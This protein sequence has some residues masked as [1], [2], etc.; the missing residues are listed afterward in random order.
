MNKRNPVSVSSCYGSQG[1]V[2]K[3][4]V[5]AQFI[6]SSPA[7]KALS[8]VTGQQTNIMCSFQLSKQLHK[9]KNTVNGHEALQWM[10]V[11]KIYRMQT[12]RRGP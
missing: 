11:V 5:L 8:F 2:K 1:T 6:R 4:S 10:S 3:K 7:G 12:R 9:H